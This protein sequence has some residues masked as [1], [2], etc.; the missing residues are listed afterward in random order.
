MMCNLVFIKILRALW[1]VVAE[2]SGSPDPSSG[3]VSSG[4]WVRIP[5]VTLNYNCL[6]KIGK[7][8]HSAVPARLLVDDTHDAYIT[9]WEGGNPV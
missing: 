3:V 9:D 4:V 7:V 6:E 2:Q 1:R 8:L 5:V